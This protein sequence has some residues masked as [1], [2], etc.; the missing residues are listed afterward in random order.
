MG[1]RHDWTLRPELMRRKA[2]PVGNWPTV[3]DIPPGALVLDSDGVVKQKVCDFL[4]PVP[5]VI[6]GSGPLASAP[7][8]SAANQN[9]WYQSTDFGLCK[10]VSGFLNEGV[11][12]VSAGRP[13]W[14]PQI[15]PN[16]AFSFFTSLRIKKTVAAAQYLISL[17]DGDTAATQQLAVL[18]N[19]GGGT[20]SLRIGGVGKSAAYVLPV[21]ATILDICITSNGTI[22]D[23]WIGGAKVVS[24]LVNG[25][26]TSAQNLSIFGYAANPLYNAEA[27][28]FQSSIFSG[29]SATGTCANLT[30]ID[31]YDMNKWDGSTSGKS[32]MGYGYTVT[33]DTPFTELSYACVPMS[34]L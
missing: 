32:E 20:V 21:P 17:A 2:V 24:G 5:V 34:M 28:F 11:D 16:M 22:S 23:L 12:F 8:A 13:A 15:A 26:Y 7:V 9:M 19:Q 27:L 25:A 18:F 10:Y 6:I 3:A 1:R 29:Y 31:K 30:Q 4:I 33:K 14:I